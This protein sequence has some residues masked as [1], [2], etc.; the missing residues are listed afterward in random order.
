MNE[1]DAFISAYGY[2]AVFIGTLLEGETILI[3]AGL[4]AHHG[5]LDLRLVILISIIGGTLGD[6]LAF[7]LGRW[8]G[9]ALIDRF[10][11]L[12]QQ[13]PKVH[14]LLE[15]YDAMLILTLRFV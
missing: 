4:A 14:A 9:E 3:A 5:L 11:F 6:Q 2:F 10:E 12:A 7:L 8:K 13:K 1:I 15:R